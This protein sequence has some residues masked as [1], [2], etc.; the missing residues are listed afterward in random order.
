MNKKYLDRLAGE[1][2]KEEMDAFLICPGEEFKFLTG[3]NPMFCERF[4][5]LF[6]KKNGEAFYICN[7][8]YEEELKSA[9]PESIRIYSWVDGENMTDVVNEVLTSQGLLGGRIGVNSTAQGFN[10]LEIASKMKVDFVNGKP[11]LEKIR[12][13]KDRDELDC[14]R[15]SAGIADKVFEKVLDI[16]RPGVSEKEIQDFLMENMVSLGG[17]TPEC[18]VGC[19]ANS[20]YPHYSDNKGVVKDRDIVLLDYGCTYRGLYSD[21]SRTVFVGKPDSKLKECY[22]LVLRANEEAEAMVTEGAYVPDIDRKA[23]E[24][25][26]EK[27]YAHTLINRLGHGIGYTVHEAPD[28][29]QSNKIKLMKGMAFS[30]EPGIYIGGEFGIRIEDIM[31]VNEEGRGE[32]LNKA[33]KEL[34]EL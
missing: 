13:I 15:Y 25:L 30:I 27:G 24:V 19:G 31:I 32:R 34:I 3:L 8:L 18:I 14:L 21:M 6:V 12:M 17:D 4:Q 10:L 26:D 23:R 9:L 16:I 20:S 2:G 33:T 29:K 22:E 1:L 5:G 7:L 11:L 28:I